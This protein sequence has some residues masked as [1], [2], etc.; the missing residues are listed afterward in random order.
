MRRGEKTDLHPAEPR[1]RLDDADLAT[2]ADFVTRL[3]QALAPLEGADLHKPH[4]FRAMAESHRAVIEALSAGADGTIAAYAGADGEALSLA[5]DDIVSQPADSDLAIAPADYPEMFK[6]VISG[7]VVH[8][9][10]LA[11]SRVRIYGPLEARLTSA[12]RVVLGSLV[13]GVW[14]PEAKTDPWLS[15]PMRLS[16]G[17]DLPERRIGLSAHDFAQMLGAKEVIL[18]RSLK[19]A[20]APTVASRFLQRLAAVAGEQRWSEARARG[21]NYLAWTKS[22]DEPAQVRPVKRP[23]PTPPRA[24]RPTQLS[25]TEI[26]HWLR[27]PYTIYAKHIL[28]LDRLDPVDMPLS[29]AERGSAIHGA[30]GEF[31]QKFPKNI[32]ADALAELLRIGRTHFA[33]IEDYP[34]ARAFW[35]PR[36]EKIARWFVNWESGRREHIAA[37]LAEIRGQISF[38]LGERT[39]TLS[40]RADRIERLADGR[41]AILDYKTGAAPTGRQ[42][43]AGVAPQLT[44]EAAILRGG[45]F[46]DKGIPAGVSVG[47]LVYV[48]LKGGEDGGEAKP[49]DFEDKTTDGAADHALARLKNLALKFEDEATPY[50]SLVLS[51]WKTRYGAYDDLARVKEW[52][53]TGGA[54][55]GDEE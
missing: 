41:Y 54:D 31:T 19:L 24:A 3:A 52:S 9:P 26:E 30:I 22:L 33:P 21:E 1:C 10:E 38:Q 35:W 37:T 55:E 43:R 6:T 15:R 16:L 42:V 29:A 44:L 12:D 48:H 17:L 7:R 8:G 14:P 34:E 5:F 25:V 40:A 39:F 50:R 49:I 27:D 32:P 20:G 47:E 23:R 11:S 28:K 51:M 45:G 46:A 53:L 2:A 18:T 13:E 36:F 4:F